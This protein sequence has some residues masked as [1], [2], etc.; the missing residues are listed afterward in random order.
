[1]SRWGSP[2]RE[3]TARETELFPVPLGPSTVT[4]NDIERRG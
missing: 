2:K 3:A 4:I 1:V